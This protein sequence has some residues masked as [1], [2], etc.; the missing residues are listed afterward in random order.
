MFASGLVNGARIVQ[1][2]EGFDPTYEGFAT[3]P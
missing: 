3:M 1:R 2:V